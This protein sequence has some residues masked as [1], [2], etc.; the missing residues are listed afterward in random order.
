M[1]FG[2]YPYGP[3]SVARHQSCCGVVRRKSD[4][5]MHAVALHDVGL[6]HRC[7]FTSYISAHAAALCPV[8]L[9]HHTD[10]DEAGPSFILW[11][12]ST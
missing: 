5:G 6:C 4:V 11:I 8:G 9:C 10:A 1:V 3:R 2:S 12:V 7:V